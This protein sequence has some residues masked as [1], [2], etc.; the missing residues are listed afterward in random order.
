MKT[1]SKPDSLFFWVVVALSLTG[2][3]IFSS[4]SLGLL[5]RDGASFNVVALKQLIALAIG[6]AALMIA[7]RVDYRY[8]R[9]FSP[10]FFILAVLFTLMI[11]VPNL[12]LT[13]GG[14]RRWVVIGPFTV[15]PSEFLKLAFVLYL[16]AHLAKIKER[17]QAFRFGFWPFLLLASLVGILQILQPDVDTLVIML[18]AGLAMYFVAGAPWSHLLTFGLILSVAMGAVILIRPYTLAR[19]ETFFHP[20]KNV[21]GASYQVNQSLIAI[22][23]GGWSGRGFGQSI[24]KFSYLPEPIG[25]SIFSVA[26]E[27]FGFLG[28]TVIVALFLLFALAGLRVAA[29][30]PTL[31]GRLTVVGL[32]TMIMTG[33]LANMASMLALIPLTGTPLLFISHGGTALLLTLLEAGI[34][35]NISR[36]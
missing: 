33:V 3:F 6:F 30:A 9:D 32:I 23:S 27:E 1:A 34:I 12:G 26:G 2:F 24:Q 20:D 16:A 28:T 14:A 18:M 15:Q 17:V 21:L 35:L 29:R 5:S 25:D 31:F 8:W 22:G 19:V 7:S 13:F 36:K 11:F 10:F 4:A